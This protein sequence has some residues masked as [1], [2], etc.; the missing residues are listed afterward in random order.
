[1][2]IKI[3]F[4]T[5]IMM[6]SAKVI[7]GLPLM[8]NFDKANFY[9]VLAMGS[10]EDI[11]TQVTLVEASGIKE[12]EAYK[13]TLLMKEA[14]LLQKPKDKLKIF[15]S[16]ATYLELAIRGDSSNV[17]YRFL[18]LT[19]QEHAPKVV[20]YHGAINGDSEFIKKHFSKLSPVVQ[21]EVYDYS[22]TST[23]LH[24]EDFKFATE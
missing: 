13:G 19:I 6:V 11:N 24:P 5:L 12:K 20:R 3:F 23:F 8:Q 4:F 9:K 7:E 17:E 2:K 1:M 18:R 15:K 21:H 22:K 14:S 10:I 16:G